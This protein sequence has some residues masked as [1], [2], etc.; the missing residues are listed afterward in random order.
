[1]ARDGTARLSRRWE[2]D[3]EPRLF[4]SREGWHV[5]VMLSELSDAKIDRQLVKRGE[6]GHLRC[7]QS[8]DLRALSQG[9]HGHPQAE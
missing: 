9:T 8:G 5:I 4:A 3:I 2:N 1:M 7:H 6:D